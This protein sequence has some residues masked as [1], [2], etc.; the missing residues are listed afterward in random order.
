VLDVSCEEQLRNTVREELEAALRPIREQLAR[1]SLTAPATSDED[2]LSLGDAAVVSGY[3]PITLRKAIRAKALAG[4]K[5]LKEWRVRRGDLK[6]WMHRRP[7][8]GALRPVDI[9][10][11]VDKMLASV[12]GR[13]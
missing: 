8:A 2:E 12:G 7:N 6:A 9:S 4:V 13:R 10:A 1:V 11:E 5:G 3:S